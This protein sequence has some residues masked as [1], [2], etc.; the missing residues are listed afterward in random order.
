MTFQ[1]R[2][3]AVV[4]LRFSPRQARFLV[5]V[6]LHSGYC[7]RR[8]YE[9]F[10]GVRYGKNVRAFLDGLVARGLAERF[11]VRADRGHVYHVRG[12]ALY[13]AIGEEEHRHRRSVGPAQIGRRLMV[14]DAVLARPDV[15]WFATTDDK[16]ELFTKRV[17]VP[18]S[19]LSSRII[20]QHLPMFVTGE[21]IMPHFLY[22]ATDG[23][24]EPFA[25]FLRDHARL[26]RCL[27]RWAVVAVGVSPRPLLQ[28]V[29]AD[30]VES[31]SSSL[32]SGYEDLR[33]YFE[34]RQVVD[35]GELAQVSVFDLRRYRDLRQRFATPA[36]D[37]LYAEWARTGQVGEATHG[38]PTGDSIGTLLLE[39]LPF[40]YEQ[41][42]SLPGV[43]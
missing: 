10:A 6:A 27:P 41:F 23:H 32:P 15:T 9:A 18:A 26:F 4:A 1:D 37:E 24:P 31:L 13:R 16:V 2:V 36:H 43:A 11:D 7:L 42:G 30:F 40:A 35:R 19:A 22:L 34:R 28:R 29:F 3:E 14:L 33:W 39:A 20:A 21:S 12:R 38:S 5:T 8:H 25:T 17:G